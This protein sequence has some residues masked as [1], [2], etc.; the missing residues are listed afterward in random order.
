MS[1]IIDFY[2]DRGI[3]CSGH[4][5]TQLLMASDK[6]WEDNH[7]FIQ[8]VFPS[9][10]PSAYNLTAPILTK[11]DIEVFTTNMQVR[12][13]VY[14]SIQR[15]MEFLRFQDPVTTKPFWWRERDHNQLR[16][17]RALNFFYDCCF[18][19]ALGDFKNRIQNLEAAHPNIISDTT[20]DFWNQNYDSNLIRDN[21]E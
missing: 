1:P 20:Y 8:W 3:C 15:F 10:E 16:I 13:N 17:T 19:E 7:S 9:I 2:S 12:Y 6:E 4:S 5:R 18:D 11:A 14:P 21:A